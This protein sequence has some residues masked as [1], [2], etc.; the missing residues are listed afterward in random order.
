[1]TLYGRKQKEETIE[2]NVFNG[3]GLGS[4]ERL[5]KWDDLINE[6]NGFIENGEI[7]IELVIQMSRGPQAELI[8]TERTGDIF[9]FHL[10]KASQLVAVRSEEFRK[11]E[12]K[13]L[14]LIHITSNENLVVTLERLDG[15]KR[16]ASN[17]TM[18]VT[19]NSRH[20]N[21]KWNVQKTDSKQLKIYETHDI[22]FA[23]P[24]EQYFLNDEA[25]I[26]IQLT[27]N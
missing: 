1:M 10:K 4:G 9:L 3:K 20:G 13:W 8:T 23:A 18:T 11:M 2:A 14:F 16:Y 25:L 7:K 26:K 27:F 21:K 6:A 24:W 15:K 12:Q 22:I 19:I 17:V 5:C